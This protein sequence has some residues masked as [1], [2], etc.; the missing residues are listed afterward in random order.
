LLVVCN[1]KRKVVGLTVQRTE[2]PVLASLTDFKS[3]SGFFVE[4]VVVVISD[5]SVCYGSGSAGICGLAV[6]IVE[7]TVLIISQAAPI[8]Y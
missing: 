8:V 1:L 4:M 7:L 6:L 2:T 5:D 3:H